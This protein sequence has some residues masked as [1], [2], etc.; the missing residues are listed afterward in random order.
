MNAPLGR[1][2][3]P[4]ELVAGLPG[5]KFYN[6]LFQATNRLLTQ[7]ATPDAIRN[8]CITIPRGD[9]ITGMA[10]AMMDACPGMYYLHE[11]AAADVVIH[12]YLDAVYA[13]GTH[14]WT[15]TFHTTDTPAHDSYYEFRF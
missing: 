8:R 13:Y 14:G 10:S 4:H 6:F 11:E 5:V 9:L 15:I 1:P 3:S 2:T 7:H 12:N